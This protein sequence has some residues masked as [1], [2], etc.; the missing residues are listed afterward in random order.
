MS[1]S[2]RVA[3]YDA[4]RSFR[5]LILL[6]AVLCSSF[7]SRLARSIDFDFGDGLAPL[8]RTITHFPTNST[9]SHYLLN[10]LH[11]TN[12]AKQRRQAQAPANAPPPPRRLPVEIDRFWGEE[13]KEYDKWLYQFEPLAELEAWDDARR[14][15]YAKIHLRGRAQDEY[16]VFAT[17]E[18]AAGRSVTWDLFNEFIRTTF[19]SRNPVTHWTQ[20]LMG[21]RQ[22]KDALASYTSKFRQALTHLRHVQPLWRAISAKNPV[23]AHNAFRFSR[24]WIK[25]L[26]D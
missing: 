4:T 18:E 6:L 13:G 24:S 17:V 3:R 22:G 16:R 12:M 8:R 2:R 9:L 5:I 19:G 21:L 15:Q 14:L 10:R 1:R 23:Q 11:K 26:L 7:G 25:P 20:N